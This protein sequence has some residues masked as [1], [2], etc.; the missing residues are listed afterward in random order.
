L[1]AMRMKPLKSGFVLIAAQ[2]AGGF[3]K[4]TMLF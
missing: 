4:P 3:D 1:E 2:L